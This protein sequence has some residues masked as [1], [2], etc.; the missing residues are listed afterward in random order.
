[1]FD[2]SSVT[3]VGLY[4]SLPQNGSSDPSNLEGENHLGFMWTAETFFSVSPRFMLGFFGG[5][6]YG[7]GNVIKNTSGIKTNSFDAILGIAARF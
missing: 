1:M 4:Y 7:F 6:K 2:A 3:F 5:L